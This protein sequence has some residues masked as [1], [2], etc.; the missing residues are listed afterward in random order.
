M[1]SRP[2]Y[3]SSYLSRERWISFVHQIDLIADLKPTSVL[4]VGIGPGVKKMMVESTFPGC[5]YTGVDIDPSLNPDIHADVRSLPVPEK[6]YDA[7]FCCQV[8]EHLPYDDF[9]PSVRELQRIARRRLVISLPDVRPFVYL[10]A[11]PPSS[12]RFLPFLWRGFSLPSLWPSAINFEEH[13]QHHWEVGRSGYPARRIV[14]D[15][16]S[17][18]WNL[19]KDF[20]MVERNY[21]HF[22]VLD[23]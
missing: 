14:S 6:S 21:W 7:A 2:N 4:E 22:F 1:P 11:R 10:R 15:L 13:G 23:R 19:T 16:K 20:R 5:R 17:T 12:K 18:G 8:L 3:D 9:L